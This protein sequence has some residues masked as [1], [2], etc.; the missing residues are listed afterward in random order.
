MRGAVEM[1][2]RRHQ[3]R[4]REA[5]AYSPEV[6][7][8]LAVDR[9]DEQQAARCRNRAAGRSR[10]R[11]HCHGLTRSPRHPDAH[12]RE[13]LLDVERLGDVVVRAGREALLLIVLPRLGGE[14]DDRQLLEAAGACAISRVAVRPS[15][16][17]I[18]TSIEHQIDGR[19]GVE[20]RERLSVSSASRPLRRD[21]D[22]EDASAR[23]RS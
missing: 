7:A 15:I 20:P 6:V 8:I 23:A 2:E 9:L 16:S 5:R 13:Q 3:P 21:L 10:A 19:A 14:G 22:L 12:E 18:M 11:A 1:R 17:G 4:R